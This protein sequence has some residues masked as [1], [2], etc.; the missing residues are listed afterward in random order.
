MQL[1]WV[2]AN[3]ARANFFFFQFLTNYYSIPVAI[4]LHIPGQCTCLAQMEIFL[5]YS[6]YFNYLILFKWG[7]LKLCQSR[8]GLHTHSLYANKNKLILQY[9]GIVLPKQHSRQYW[10][11]VLK[12][13]KKRFDWLVSN[14]NYSYNFFIRPI[15]SNLKMK[16]IYW[17]SPIPPYCLNFH[18]FVFIYFFKT[19]ILTIFMSLRTRGNKL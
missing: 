17:I 9:L 15:L 11:S 10:L 13:P 6:L 2:T 8:L 1:G 5:S 4:K 14:K 19:L 16:K 3:T 7:T 12:Y 18:M